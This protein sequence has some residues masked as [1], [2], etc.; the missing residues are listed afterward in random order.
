MDEGIAF[1]RDEVMPMVQGMDGCVGLSML[2][3]RESGRCI[4]TTAWETE[5]AM[6]ASA[7]GVRASRARAAEVFGA[8][9]DPEVNEWEVALMHRQR[10]AHHG[11]CARVIWG[12]GDPGRVAESMEAFRTMLPRLEEL[13]GFCSVSMMV[14]RG[15]GRSATA[16]GYD[17]RADMMQ[18]ADR[19]RGLR[20]EFARATGGE[21]T[22]VAE[23]DLELSHLRVPETV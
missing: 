23:F 12:R 15:S 6:R 7:E 22:E 5:E 11:A 8:G 9:G 17:S 3:D 14:D 2:C 13:P 18:A 21:V 20:E 19:G 16:V 4:I 1:V 10:E